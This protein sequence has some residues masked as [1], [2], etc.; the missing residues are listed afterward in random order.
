MWWE[1]SGQTQHGSY[2][3]LR[4][5]ATAEDS[6]GLTLHNLDSFIPSGTACETEPPE[7][8]IQHP[9]FADNSG[10]QRALVFFGSRQVCLFH[11][12]EVSF[13]LEPPEISGPTEPSMILQRRR[14]VPVFGVRRDFK[15]P[16]QFD[17]QD[18]R[19]LLGGNLQ[20]VAYKVQGEQILFVTATDAGWSPLRML[21]VRNGLT[22]DQAIPLVEN[23]AR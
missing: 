10:V 16:E 19:M 1:G 6:D 11:L 14:H 18:A 21:P 9:L 3:L 8:A 12:M 5:T 4:L 20:P 17:M 2:A 23:L 13:V 22:L 15:A 7:A